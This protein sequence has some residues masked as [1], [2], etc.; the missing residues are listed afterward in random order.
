MNARQE[1][2]R[3]KQ[4]MRGS[5][6]SVAGVY[7]RSIQVDRGAERDA[8]NGQTALIRRLRVLFVHMAMIDR[9]CTEIVGELCHRQ[10]AVAMAA[11]RLVRDEHVSPL[12]REVIDLVRP[13]RAAPPVALATDAQ[14]F[15]SAFDTRR[16]IRRIPNTRLKIAAKPG[17]AR[18]A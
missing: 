12:F 10:K 3:S 13:D 16:D 2:F 14:E 1:S 9:H 17:D 15:A 18:P 4:R 8:M 7:Y 11:G 5:S 6:R